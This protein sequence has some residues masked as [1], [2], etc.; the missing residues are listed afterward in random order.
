MPSLDDALALAGSLRLL[1]DG[2]I[3]SLFVADHKLSL[4]RLC[5]ETFA[6]IF[7]H[8]FLP[9]NPAQ[10]SRFRSLKPG[11]IEL[12]AQPRLASLKHKRALFAA[13]P[14]LLRQVFNVLLLDAQEGHSQQSAASGAP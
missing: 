4:T 2:Q 13:N 9:L 1:T 6:N 11:L 14:S 8:G 10:K 12:L 7:L 3:H 5:A